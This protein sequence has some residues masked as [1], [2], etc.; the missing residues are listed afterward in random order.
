MLIQHK[1]VLQVNH[2]SIYLPDTSR[3][4][5]H[6]IN[7]SVQ[8]GEFVILLGSNGSGKSSLIAAINNTTSLKCK[9][10]IHINGKRLDKINLD[11]FVATI[12]QN[13]NSNLFP[14]LTLVENFF[15]YR[16]TLGRAYTKAYKLSLS[17]YSLPIFLDYLHHFSPKL[18]KLLHQKVGDLS[19]GEKQILALALAIFFPRK[20]LLL[21]EHTSALDPR[22]SQ[23]IMDLTYKKV[24]DY[25][26][27]CIMTTHNLDHAIA[28]GDSIIAIKNG[29]IFQKFNTDVKKQIKKDDLLSIFSS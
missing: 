23:V 27:T 3:Y 8:Q 5:L 15:V 19:G 4:V 13:V 7:F 25:G 2:F 17:A 29:E 9:G 12:T 26:L 14:S 21:D 1:P 6:N 24:R 18:T 11:L 10:T 22:A 20:I 28:H 16:D